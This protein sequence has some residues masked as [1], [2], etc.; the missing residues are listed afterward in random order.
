MKE[1]KQNPPK[2]KHAPSWLGKG[3]RSEPNLKPFEKQARELKTDKLLA[4]IDK[5]KL[6]SD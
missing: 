5:I 2:L 1:L 6:S 4:E 3:D